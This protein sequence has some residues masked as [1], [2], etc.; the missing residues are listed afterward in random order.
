MI[1]FLARDLAVLAIAGVSDCPLLSLLVKAKLR[2]V[3]NIAD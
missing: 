1:K 3:S 2:G